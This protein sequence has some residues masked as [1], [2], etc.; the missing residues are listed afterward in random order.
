MFLPRKISAL[1]AL[2]LALPVLHL[3]AAVEVTVPWEKSWPV[4]SPATAADFGFVLKNPGEKAAK[5]AFKVR[6]VSP[7]GE[8]QLV[9]ESFDLPA[10]GERKIAWPLAGQEMGSWTMDYL[11][12]VEGDPSADRKRKI[13][14]GYLEPAGPNTR[15]PDFLFGV[16][17]HTERITRSEREREL[18]AA[19]YVGTKVMRTGS[20]WGHVQP[21]R[22]EWKWE[23]MDHLVSRAGE[24][25]MQIQVLLA[26]TTQWAAPLEKQKSKDWLD[27]NR[28]APDREAWRKYVSTYAERYKG[29]IHL[30]EVWNEPDLEGFW[31]GT[32]EEYLEIFQIAREELKKADPA[33]VVMSG[34]FATL[35]DHPS[36]KKNPDLQ[37]RVMK[38]ASTQMDLHAVHEH[39]SFERFAKVVDE[40]YARLR[41]AL[42]Q[43]APPIFFNETAEHALHGK[44]KE[45]ASI[46]VKKAVFARA[47]GSVGYL[48]YDLRN[49]GV[50]PGDPEHHFGLLTHAMEPKPAYIA[51]NTFAREVVS[52]PYLR[53]V[54]A[55]NNRWFFLHGD[56]REKLLVFWN[57][58]M[59]TQ[60]EQILLRLPGATG[61]RLMDING[62]ASPLPISGDLVVV[63]SCNEP[64]LL[65]A[66]GA[67]SVEVA[68]RLAGPGRSFFGGPGEEV[69]VSC[70]FSNP[71]DKSAAVRVDW[72][73]PA[74]VKMIESAPNEVTLPPQGRGLSKIKVRL[75]EQGSYLFGKSGKLKVTYAFADQ[76]YKGSLLVPI[77]YGT[78]DVPPNAA[79]RA[80][81]VVLDQREQLT[82]FI[83]ADPHLT[84]FRWK[85]PE[86][87]N[88][89][90][91]LAADSE[92]LVLKV[93][94]SDNQ[95]FQAGPAPDMWMGDSVQCVLALPGQ[96][97]SWELGVAD[98][99]TGEPLVMVWAVPAG[100]EDCRSA[101]RAEVE[102]KGEGR[103]YTV[104][105]PRK[106]IGLEDQALREGFRLN[107]AVNDNDGKVRAHALQIAPGIVS[108]KSTDSA[109]FVRFQ[110]IPPSS[111]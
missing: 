84:A 89:K 15:K 62:N 72:A 47:R 104:R 48:W 73:L 4:V 91:W 17:S 78:I 82:S 39:G 75:P 36:R 25:G 87:L 35:S 22:D 40:D 94:V 111:P 97:G 7:S 24:L 14:F 68:G 3:T 64:Q 55:G 28:A 102:R 2:L 21:A 79:G 65:F 42:P 92:D 74:T 96:K 43:P 54:E 99:A 26:F 18:E 69:E 12:T 77:H 23:T 105:I 9:S 13:T 50:D 63:N 19:A 107:V 80:P 6:L 57:E 37:E 66:D 108:S 60:N 59:G 10:G 81:D 1:A 70:E 49:D 30:W 83:E 93:A 103:V 76:P 56:A 100:K 67:E 98:S 8:E 20:E 71:S 58:D 33:N 90:L 106:A 46:L 109:P 32:T 85:G 44:E 53:Q 86:D 27:W 5:G 101:I 29:K 51:F 34:G 95:H 110:E 11:L 38:A 45:Q 31:R 61:A 16:V 52:R 41:A 88:A